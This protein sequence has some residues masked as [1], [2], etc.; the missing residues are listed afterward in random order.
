MSKAWISPE[1]IQF[2]LTTAPPHVCPTYS[3]FLPSEFSLV[4][5]VV[6]GRGLLEI[7]TRDEE[8]KMGG[9]EE[10]EEWK[11]R[12]EHE[13]EELIGLDGMFRK[14]FSGGSWGA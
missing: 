5:M 2:D 10:A 14:T 1:A 6:C 11:R 13:Q 9:K 7:V 4:L 12:E 8:R 3:V